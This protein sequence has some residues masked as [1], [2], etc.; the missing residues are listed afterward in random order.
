MSIRPDRL[1]AFKQEQRERRQAELL[2]ANAELVA[3]NARLGIESSLQTTMPTVGA[4]A[5]IG[6][7]TGYAVIRIDQLEWLADQIAEAKALA[8]ELTAELERWHKI[9]GQAGL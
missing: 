2:K 1:E 8:A 3:L 7:A 4:A 5:F 6:V 9:D